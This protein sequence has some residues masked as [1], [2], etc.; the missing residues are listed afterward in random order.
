MAFAWTIISQN[1]AL[2]NPRNAF[3]F[4]YQETETIVKNTFLRTLLCC[5]L[6]S[7]TTAQAGTIGS[8]SISDVSLGGANASA[9][10]YGSGINPQSQG[11]HGG[12]YAFG[13]AFAQ[14]GSASWTRLAAFDVLADDGFLLSS[15][16]LGP[17]LKMSFDRSDERHGS[18]TVTNAS[19]TD[20]VA[21]DLV[22]AIHTGGGSGAFLFNGARLAA[23]ATQSGDWALNLLNDG[24]NY[25]GYSNLTVFGRDPVVS[26]AT[27]NLNNGGAGEAA[28][29][30][31]PEPG[32]LPVILT[33][34][35]LL[36][37]I[38]A[39]RKKIVP[40]RQG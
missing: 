1:Q 16:A 4:F 32:T 24:G 40:R 10:D 37:V 17:V 38:S 2:P 31:V 8:A 18:W 13:P 36:G 35:G 6:L 33:G 21:L 39:R 11:P 23:G 25:A 28:A 15:S 3:A 34:L 12:S 20:D 19:K 30:A 9:L 29:S 22:F 5:T 7:A 26:A 27:A 14:F